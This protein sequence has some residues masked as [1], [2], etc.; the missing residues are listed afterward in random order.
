MM[1][2]MKDR[3]ER[4]ITDLYKKLAEQSLDVVLIFNPDGKI[5]Y[6]NPSALAT[7]GYSSDEFLKLNILEI[8]VSGTQTE[9]LEQLSRVRAGSIRLNV[10]HRRK[11]GTIFPAESTWTHGETA[12]EG[13]VILSLIRDTSERESSR[14]DYQAALDQLRSSEERYQRL[15]EQT[16]DCIFIASP[17]GRYTDV[18]A[19]GCAMFGMTREELLEASLTDLLH[20]DEY[21]RVLPTIERLASG[22]V[23]ELGEWRYIRKD[24]SEFIGDLL[25]KQMPDGTLQGILRDVTERRLVEQQLRKTENTLKVFYET[26]PICMGITEIVDDD[27]LHVYDNPATCRFF[28]VDT[29]ATAGKLALAELGADPEVV[30]LWIHHYRLAEKTQLPVRFE[31]S[32]QTAGGKQYLAVTVNVLGVG[33]NGRTRYCYVADDITDR[34]IAEEE[35]RNARDTLEDTVAARTAELQRVALS[36]RDEVEVRKQG[37]TRLREVM[38]HLVTI[39]EEERRRIGRNIHDQLG[40][41]LTGLRINLANLVSMTSDLTKVSSLTRSIQNLAEE[42]DSSIDFVTWELI[43]GEISTVGPSEALRELVNVWSQRFGIHAEYNFRGPAELSISDQ[44]GTSL[45]RITQEALHNIVKHAQASRAGV[46]FEVD[47]HTAKLIVED[48]GKGFVPTRITGDGHSLGLISMRERAASIDGTL[49]IES[50]KDG[51]TIFVR[52]PLA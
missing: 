14:R 40:Q 28:G 46:L 29:W 16:I 20:P 41:Q 52:I 48:D 8:R 21:S 39:Q 15:F 44:V 2:E 49:E 13:E 19:A 30:K 50:S 33:D 24:G 22:Q 3:V 45:Y 37:E 47:G 17:D 10:L 9:Y 31:H 5:L 7:Y 34:R 36:L 25:G 12:N 43:P 18:N 4:Q 11:D 35:V 42:L 51:T 23:L 1:P 26:S 6:A 27:V 32:H 38:K